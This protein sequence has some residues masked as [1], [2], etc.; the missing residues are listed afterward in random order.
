MQPSPAASTTVPAAGAARARVWP[1]RDSAADAWLVAATVV[2]SAAVACGLALA[3]R[4]DAASGYAVAALLLAGFVWWGSNTVAHIH[5]HRPIFAVRA[6]NRAFS[7]WLTLF[8]GVPQSLWRHRHLWHHAGEPRPM[9]PLRLGRQAIAEF[10][11]VVVAWGALAA[12]EQSAFI[13]AWLPG[14]ALGMALCQLQG[15]TEH[16]LPG[17]SVAEGISHYGKLYNLFWFHDGHHAEHHRWPA[18]HW[19]TLSALRS[20]LRGKVECPLPPFARPWL[21]ARVVANRGIGAALTWLERVCLASPGLQR[22]MVAVHTRAIRAVLRDAGLRPS[23]VTVVGGGLFPRTLAVLRDVAPDAEVTVVDADDRHV[24]VARTWLRTHGIDERKVSFRIA[25]FDPTRD[26]DADLVVLPLALIGD[27]GALTAGLRG[28]VLCHAW[29]WQG[30]AAAGRL[31][32]MP[33]TATRIVG[34]HIVAWRLLKRVNLLAPV[35]HTVA[36]GR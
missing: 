34:T 2:Q 11:L 27:A 10:A 4:T 21:G 18:A 17:Q 7:L 29:L 30:A 28:H 19:T 36:A 8:T 32:T 26:G 13:F 15:W 6:L 25:W 9:P 16:T 14:F 24:E 33:T 22:Y 31:P 23:T 5:L 1:L 35:R 3:A 12:T 20:D